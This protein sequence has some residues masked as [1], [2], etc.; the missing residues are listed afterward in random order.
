MTKELDDCPKC[1]EKLTSSDYCFNCKTWPNGRKSGVV[2]N[3]EEVITDSNDALLRAVDRTT[4][5]IRSLAIFLFTTLCTSLLGYGLI[6]A[7][8]AAAI[9]CDS[10]YSD[11]GSGFV[12]WGWIIIALGFIIGLGV[13]ITELGKSKPLI[14]L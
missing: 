14:G 9:G 7:G 1:G 3:V 5:A 10:Y 12:I 13:G 6:G 8:A 2:H 4:Y 11:C